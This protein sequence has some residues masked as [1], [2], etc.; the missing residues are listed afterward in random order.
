MLWYSAL[1]PFRKVPT[2]SRWIH[3]R[4]STVQ[5]V[6]RVTFRSFYISNFQVDSSW[7]D[8][9][10]SKKSLFEFFLAATITHSLFYPGKLSYLTMTNIQALF[11]LS[12]YAL[13]SD[14]KKRKKDHSDL[15][16][17]WIILVFND[18]RMLYTF[19]IIF[20]NVSA[21]IQWLALNVE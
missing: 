16:M 9:V 20:E 18:L 2:W 12:V 14:K 17:T 21:L 15:N 19:P 4:L 10:T 13:F 8:I 1:P 11:F 7:L 6:L 3:I 5:I